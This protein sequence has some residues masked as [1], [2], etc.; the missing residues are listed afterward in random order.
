VDPVQRPLPDAD[1]A[2]RIDEATD[3]G[4][5]AAPASGWSDVGPEG[6]A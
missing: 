5:S 6:R 3:A 1:R 4:G 2:R